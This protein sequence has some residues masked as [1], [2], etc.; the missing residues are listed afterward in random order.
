MLELSQSKQKTF[1]ERWESRAEWRK[2]RVG[3]TSE[4]VHLS[5]GGEL[6]DYSLTF[7]ISKWIY[8]HSCLST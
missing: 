2:E 3:D 1:A 7:R 6:R 4:S 5:T 8:L